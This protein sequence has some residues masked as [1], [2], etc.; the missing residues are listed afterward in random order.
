MKNDRSDF[1]H[2]NKNISNAIGVTVII[3]VFIRSG[4]PQ[5]SK[6]VIRNRILLHLFSQ[7]LL[8]QDIII[9]RPWPRILMVAHANRNTL[10]FS[11]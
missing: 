4:G 2:K 5:G 11:R 10:C 6:S 1:E 3:F 9:Q 7:K 8:I